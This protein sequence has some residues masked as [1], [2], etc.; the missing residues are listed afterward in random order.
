MATATSRGWASLA[1]L[2]RA[3]VAVA[4]VYPQMGSAVPTVYVAGD[5]TA[6]YFDPADPATDTRQGYVN[7]YWNSR[8]STLHSY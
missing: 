8:P 5:S 3:V 2:L 4:M 6:A 1:G 7:T